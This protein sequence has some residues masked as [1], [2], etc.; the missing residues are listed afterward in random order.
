L[1]ILTV[2]KKEAAAAASFFYA[3]Q[4]PEGYG[5]HPLNPSLPRERGT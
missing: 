5:P 4:S 3:P 1:G 2:K